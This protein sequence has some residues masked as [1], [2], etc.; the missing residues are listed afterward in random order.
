MAFVLSTSMS[1]SWNV[2]TVTSTSW[3]VSL[4]TVPI[5]VWAVWKYDKRCVNGDPFV[6]FAVESLAVNDGDEKVKAL[7]EYD[8]GVL[9]AWSFP[10]R[11]EVVKNGS[12]CLIEIGSRCM[13]KR[14][15]FV[16]L[17]TGPL[18]TT[19]V[20]SAVVSFVKQTGST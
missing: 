17:R 4:K 9:K 18:N 15:I 12:P 13:G 5:N 8:M 20:A 16:T 14:V 11:S 6:Y 2:W 10:R 19:G 3:T 7:V 1:S